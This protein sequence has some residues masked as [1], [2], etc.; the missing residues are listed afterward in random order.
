MSEQNEAINLAGRTAIEGPIAERV[1][2][3]LNQ[4]N[5]TLAAM[6]DAIR[7]VHVAL[8]DLDDEALQKS[9]E[10]ESRELTTN[11]AIQERRRELQFELAPLLNLPPQDVTIRRLT[12]ATSG[13]ARDS[14]ESIWHSLT[15]MTTEIDRLNRQNAAMIGQSLMI[16]R[17]VIEQLAGVAGVGESYNAVGVRSESHV[18]PLIQWGA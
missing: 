4:E 2:D 11:V 9:L 17:N 14:I 7:G 12:A 10:A 8:R 1:L 5:N 13:N 18:G 15:E 6:L 16:A 3:H